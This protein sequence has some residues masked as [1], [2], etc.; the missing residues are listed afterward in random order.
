MRS[1]E[2]R[3]LWADSREQTG[4]N[5]ENE[6][7]DTEG[8]INAALVGADHTAVSDRRKALVKQSLEAALHW[9]TVEDEPEE[10]ESA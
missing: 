1:G 6:M 4:T 8:L 5:T 3:A 2:A 10:K 9:L 7:L